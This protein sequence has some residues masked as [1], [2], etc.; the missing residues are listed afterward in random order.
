M[1]KL[2]LILAFVFSALPVSAQVG[3][4]KRVIFAV[5]ARTIA[6]NGGGTPATLTLTPTG[7]YVTLT[8]N[9]PDGCTITMGETGIPDGMP[10]TIVNVSANPCT[11]ADTSG[12]S[13]LSGA[14]SLGQWQSI[15]LEYVTDRWV[16]SG[17]GAA[18]L[19]SAT[20]TLAVTH[21]GTG[22]TS[23][24][25]GGVLAFTGGTTVASSGALTANLPVIGGG[26]GAAPT[27]G[28]RSGNTTK[29]LTTTGTLTSG[30]CAKFD[31]SGNVVDNG[32]VCGSGGS[33][34][35]IDVE[36]GGSEST[37][38]ALSA[39]ATPTSDDLIV[40]VDDPAGTPV[41]KKVTLGDV[42]SA[43][44][45]MVRLSQIVTTSSQSTVDFTSISSA[46]TTLVIQWDAQDTTSG[47]SGSTI[48]MKVNNDGTAGNYT[49]GQRSGAVNGSALVTTVSAG[50]SGVQVG[51]IPNAGNTGMT[52]SGQI[53]IVNYAGSTFHKRVLSEW[54]SDDG[55]NNGFVSMV[56]WR[57]KSTSAITRL[58]IT[59]GTAFTDGSVFTLYGI[60]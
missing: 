14:V 59:A 33:A 28:T 42:F 27:V 38:S 26:A 54:G 31:A 55:T 46:Y 6:S 2:I 4:F 11:F 16:Q 43:I 32:G 5:D 29:F 48:T 60:R 3:N 24:T 52:G 56:E 58:T 23:G 1:K 9:D 41:N 36:S 15:N 20:G 53:R 30:N 39:D 45:G 19:A 12:V 17:G 18:D 21:G 40:T 35:A 51:F 22:L 34:T 49:S 50:T 8:C 37:I 57:W 25:S 7:S 13:E 47:T 10:V 44:G